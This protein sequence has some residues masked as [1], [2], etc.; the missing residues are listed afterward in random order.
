MCPRSIA[1]VLQVRPGASRLPY[2]CTPPVCIP[3]VSGG[4]VVWRQNN[5]KKSNFEKMTGNHPKQE[6][7]LDLT[8]FILSH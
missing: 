4:L 8:L 2:Y 7:S 5:I 1:G 3:D 6:R